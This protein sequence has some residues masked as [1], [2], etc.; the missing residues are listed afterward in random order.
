M[1]ACGASAMSALGQKRTFAVQTGMSALP[2]IADICALEAAAAA[3]M[4]E[5]VFGSQYLQIFPVDVGAAAGSSE[6]E[7]FQPCL[8][9]DEIRRVKT[10]GERSVDLAELR[11]TLVGVLSQLVQV[12]NTHAKFKFKG[13]GFLFARDLKTL[14]KK[15]SA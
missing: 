13:F 10:L 7:I 14:T 5:P 12:I 8:G 11:A 4:Y 6:P 2:P 1:S 15:C 3:P 9:P